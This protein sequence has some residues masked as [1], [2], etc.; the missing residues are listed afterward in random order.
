MIGRVYVDQFLNYINTNVK[1]QRGL[2]PGGRTIWWN[3]LK[4][5]WWVAAV[6]GEESKCYAHF[7][8]RK[9]NHNDGV[10]IFKCFVYVLFYL[11]YL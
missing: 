7:R 4:A 2:F 6:I 8:I 5:R 10:K 1:Q 3:Y 9:L 11:N